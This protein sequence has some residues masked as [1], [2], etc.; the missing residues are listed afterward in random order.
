MK[1]ILAWINSRLDI[2]KEKINIRKHGNWNH[3][4]G[5]RKVKNPE[6]K[7]NMASVACGTMLSIKYK[8][9]CSP[10]K[11]AEEDKKYI[12]IFE[13]ITAEE[14]LNLIQIICP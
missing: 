2:A 5:N 1:N 3:P 9:N 13:E 7:L 14:F 6:N 10:R 8:Y 11:R 12:Y 4:K